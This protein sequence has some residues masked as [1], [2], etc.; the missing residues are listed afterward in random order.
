MT[1][2]LKHRSTDAKRINGANS[3]QNKA[4]VANGAAGNAPFH[5][6]LGKSVECAVNDV[7]DPQNHQGWRKGLVRFGQHL[8]VETQKCIPPHFQ[9]YTSQEHRHG[10][11]GFSV[12]IRK[13]GMKREHRQLH[14]ESHQEPEITKQPKTATGRTRNQ[15]TQIQGEHISRKRQC[16]ATD[17]DQ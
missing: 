15:F 14:A 8:N 10:S 17:Q 9:E 1:H 4:H 13:P 5:V 11:I 7:H 12:G 6:V 2:H 3:H 16:E